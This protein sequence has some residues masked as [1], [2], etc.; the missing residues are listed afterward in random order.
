MNISF[1]F[2]EGH[3]NAFE[4]IGISRNIMMQMFLAVMT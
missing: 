4:E 3:N 2:P 1:K